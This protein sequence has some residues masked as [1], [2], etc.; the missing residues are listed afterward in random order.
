M[1][2]LPQLAELLSDKFGIERTPRALG[3]ALAELGVRPTN[4]WRDQD[5]SNGRVGYYDPLVCWAVV[6]ADRSIVPRRVLRARFDEALVRASD[7]VWR[8][9]GGKA[10]SAPREV[11]NEWQW[12]CQATAVHLFVSDPRHGLS[13]R[14]VVELRH[15]KLHQHTLDSHECL[16]DTLT[17]YMDVLSELLAVRSHEAAA[18]LVSEDAQAERENRVLESLDSYGVLRA[19][20]RRLGPAPCARRVQQEPAV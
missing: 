6:V 13:P 2:T 4:V 15:R 5:T 19:C 20:D 16:A 14:D 17:I 11:R 7:A 3:K 1:L 9:F 12:R 8:D 10:D 18:W